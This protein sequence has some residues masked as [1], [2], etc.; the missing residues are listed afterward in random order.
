MSKGNDSRYSIG[1]QR[2]QP[3]REDIEGKK[4]D[5]GLFKGQEVTVPKG[6]VTRVPPRRITVI[7]EY[8][9]VVALWVEIPNDSGGTNG[10]AVSFDKASLFCGHVEIKDVRGR[11][12]GAGVR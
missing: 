11:R 5:L 4:T 7:G 3:S 9:H 1:Y 2:Y 6:L 12:I 8:P 10:Y